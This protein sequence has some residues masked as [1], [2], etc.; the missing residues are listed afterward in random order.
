M[1]VNAVH[2]WL[3]DRLAAQPGVRAVRRPVS[4]DGDNR[5]DL[6]YVRTGPP[7]DCPLVIIPGGP[8]VASIQHYRVLRHRLARSGVD[9]LMIEHRGVGLSRHDDH[10]QDLPPDALTVAQVVDDVAAVLD[11]EGVAQAD[12]YGT[13]YGSYLAAGVGVRHR[14]RVH[15]MVLDSPVL[16]AQ[17]ITAS[18][19]AV[20]SLLLDGGSPDGDRVAP[21]V[22]RLIERG[23][24][25]ATSVEVASTVYGYGG[26][27]LLERQLD[28]LL[29]G[30]TI[31]WQGVELMSLLPLRKV[32]YHN[33]IDLAGR[34]AFREL[35][36]VGQPDG[37]PLDPSESMLLMRDQ[38]AGATP[39]FESEPYDL[40][41]EMPRFDW[42]TVVL[43]GGR[44]LITP[45]ALA[46][47]IAALIPDA[48]LVRLPTAPHSVLDFR[49]PVATEV[50]AALRG[51]RW[52]ELADRATELD[53]QS[54]GLPQRLLTSALTAAAVLEGLLPLPA[55]S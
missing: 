5:F 24:L 42:P 8:G 38:I 31:V 22:R 26:I 23:A 14:S 9:V 7:S 2:K 40:V 20:R 30:R 37:L 53:S 48:V 16:S 41:A 35:D 46:E 3:D 25:T 1:I 47:R 4:T 28:L 27:D 29:R 39:E 19:D 49:E 45:V 51:G 33:E 10:G 13:S 12:L 50:I 6:R 44:D 32:P 11:A 36:Y 15:A 43:S 21:K 54:S 52:R 17:D 34:I 55:T 18:R